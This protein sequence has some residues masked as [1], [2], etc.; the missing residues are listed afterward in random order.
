MEARYVAEPDSRR[1]RV[2]ELVREHLRAEAGADIEGVVATLTSRPTYVM[3]SSPND[4]RLNPAGSRDGVRAFYDTTIVQTGAHRLEYAC[5]RVIA[6]DDAVF[7]EGMM[8]IAYPGSTLQRMGIAVDDT[9]A[10]YVAESRM[11]IVWPYDASEDRLTGEEV[12][13]SSDAF[14]GIASRKIALSD[15]EPLRG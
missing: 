6:D 1:K 10:Y 14:A 13:S 3:H 7:T 8:R 2:L 9:D 4:R 15:I 12:Y 5:D 11:G